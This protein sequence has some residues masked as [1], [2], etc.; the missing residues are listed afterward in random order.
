MGDPAGDAVNVIKNRGRQGLNC[1]LNATVLQDE[2][3]LGSSPEGAVGIEYKCLKAK[4]CELQLKLAEN[5]QK[6]N[7]LPT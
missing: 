4:C 1:S 3:V 7:P 6:K 5:T 2:P